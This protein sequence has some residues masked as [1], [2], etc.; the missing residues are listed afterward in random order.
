M[1][2]KNLLVLH[3]HILINNSMFCSL[4]L[5]V[6]QNTTVEDV[7]STSLC[8]SYVSMLLMVAAERRGTNKETYDK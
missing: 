2:S 3:L 8:L 6:N 1:S 7:T 5:E 4:T